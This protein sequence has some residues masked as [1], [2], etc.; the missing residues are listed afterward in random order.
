LAGVAGFEYAPTTKSQLFGYYGGTYFQR[1]YTLAS[2][3]TA[4]ARK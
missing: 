2:A 4:K 3:N 1:N